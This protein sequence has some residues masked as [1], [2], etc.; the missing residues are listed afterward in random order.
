MEDSP[1]NLLTYSTPRERW[2]ESAVRSVSAIMVG[3]SAMLAAFDVVTLCLIRFG[4]SRTALGFGYPRWQLLHKTAMAVD[5]LAAGLVLLAA[6][7]YALR[8][9]FTA[10]IATGSAVLVAARIL[11]AIYSANL[12]GMS[13]RQD[14]LGRYILTYITSVVAIGTIVPLANLVWFTRPPVRRVMAMRAPTD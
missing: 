11:D 12:Y 4:D 13:Q 3:S 6:V 2:G 5:A 9:S 10:V 8:R 14:W 7:Q 1:H